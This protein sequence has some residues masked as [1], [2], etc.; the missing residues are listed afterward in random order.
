MLLLNYWWLFLRILVGF[1]ISCTTSSDRQNICKE[2]KDK[3]ANCKPDNEANILFVR[4]RG[5]SWC[6]SLHVTISA[7]VPKAANIFSSNA[8]AFIDRFKGILD[9]LK[10][11]AAILSNFHILVNSGSS[12]LVTG[13][14]QGKNSCSKDS[15]FGFCFFTSTDLKVSDVCISESSLNQGD[16]HE[17]FNALLLGT[18]R[19]TLTLNKFIESNTELSEDFKIDM[20]CS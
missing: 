14:N 16:S 10:V 12:F 15:T 6:S 2:Q 8:H 7:N 4:A 19:S 18:G 11:C 3:T 5:T 20:G 17:L 13:M 9:L 1:L